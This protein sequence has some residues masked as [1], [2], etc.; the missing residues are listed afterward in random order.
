M[1]TDE[2][3]QAYLRF[4]ESK[5]HKILP[6]APLVPAGDP[7]LLLTAAGMV[8]FKPYFLGT[9][10]PEHTRV[11]TCQKCVRTG[12]IDNVGKTTRHGTF[13]EMLGNFSFGDYF[14]AE[15]I[16]WA[17]EFVTDVLGLAPENLWVTIYLDD[18]EAFNIWRDVVGVSADRIIRKG[19]KDN[20]WEIGVGPC[21]PCSEIYI[22]RGADVGCGSPECGLDCDCGRFIELWNLVFIQYHKD[23]DGNYTPL[24]RPGIDT[25]MGLERVAAVLQGAETIFDT[26]ETRVVRD[27]AAQLACVEYGADHQ[28][29]VAIRVI[30][31]HVRAAAFMVADGIFPTN[32]G[33]GYVLRRLLRRAARYGRL[34]GIEG[35][36]LPQVADTVI[37]VMAAP[38]PE[39]ARD[40]DRILKAI[41]LEEDR[42]A[43]ALEQGSVVLESI[44]AEVERDGGRMLPGEDA[45]KLYD[46]YGFPFELTEEIASERGLQ[47]DKAHFDE[48]MEAQR[49]RAR[50]ARGENAYLDEKSAKYHDAI[51]DLTTEFVG[52]HEFADTANI[53]AIIGKDG[54]SLAEL[55]ED[56]DGE[57][58]MNK[59][60]FYPTGGGQQADTGLIVSS[61]GAVAEVC[62]VSRPFESVITHQVH[63]IRG[64]L[65][66]GDRVIAYV[67]EDR[68]A[69]TMRNHTATHLIQAALRQVL[70]EHVQQAGSYV[71]GERL[72]FDF[73]HFEALTVDEL[74]QVELLANRWVMADIPVDV[75]M[76]TIDEAHRLGAI[77]LFDEKYGDEVRMVGIGDISLELCGGTHVSRTGEIGLVKIVSESGI[78]AGVR[79]IEAITGY[80]FLQRFNDMDRE[81]QS[82]AEILKVPED[83]MVERVEKLL[84]ELK[85]KEREIARLRER[86]AV[87]G[88]DSLVAGRIMVDDIPVVAAPVE[89]ADPEA[90]R[91]LADAVRDKL[92]SGIVLL[93]SKAEEKVLFVATVSRD[94]VKQGFNAGSIVR[95]AAKVAGGGGGGRPDMAQAGG[96]DV[97]KLE[98]AIEAGVDV[99][100][101]HSAS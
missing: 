86:L 24:E 66:V 12:D 88:V 69:A 92:G 52:Y 49:E 51:G 23:E 1:K 38:Y 43:A 41:A 98:A 9:A 91:N 72:R 90:L 67:D 30:T 35:S 76:T 84:D 94:L 28:S 20:F 11:T 27:R 40:R 68:R 16:P 85:E 22:D 56:Q 25:G 37:D 57:T 32:E 5:G 64:T 4:F 3:R 65:K 60:P 87:G 19:K 63:M 21:G 36:F 77:A 17:W 53:I 83:M 42:F 10:V 39:L 26:D 75:R 46:T 59:T 31:D 29:D 93:G 7:T 78:A 80:A 79:R 48:A 44:I 55:S 62:S 50:A 99:V 100:R 82:L 74:A 96:R 61:R 70:G 95:E 8:P 54:N 14:K 6:S 18:D 47:V 15:A 73:S 71:D 58:V 97:S 2:L 45:F 101:A 33:R 89:L 34:V 81:F 13:F